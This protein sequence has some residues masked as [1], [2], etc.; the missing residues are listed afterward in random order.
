V[1]GL[2]AFECSSNQGAMADSN[3]RTWGSVSNFTRLNGDW[4]SFPG[5]AAALYEE[6]YGSANASFLLF[7]NCSGGTGCFRAYLEGQAT[8]LHCHFV[9]NAVGAIAHHVADPLLSE[10]APTTLVRFCF[11]KDTKLRGS[12][13]DGSVT[14]EG[15]LFADEVEST[16]GFVS[17]GAQVANIAT[18]LVFGTASLLPTCGGVAIP[19]TPKETHRTARPR[20]TSKESTMV[21]W[22][23]PPKDLAVPSSY[24]RATKIVLFVAVNIGLVALG[25]VV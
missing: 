4:G 18:H 14:L 12:E 8:L 16:A 25:L 17:I 3:V 21:G 10:V 2:S 24:G 5:V 9:G 6:F 19:P 15:C 7:A 1:E 23:A 20:K 22:F 11:F 13:F